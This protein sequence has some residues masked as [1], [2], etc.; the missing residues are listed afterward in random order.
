MSN[1]ISQY[2]FIYNCTDIHC[3]KIKMLL[4]KYNYIIIIFYIKKK[5]LNFNI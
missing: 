3:Y 2:F 4:K 1:N 5:K